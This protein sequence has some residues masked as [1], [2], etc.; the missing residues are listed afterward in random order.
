MLGLWPFNLKCLLQ[1]LVKEGWTRMSSNCILCYPPLAQ[2][3]KAK[4]GVI[5]CSLFWRSKIFREINHCSLNYYFMKWLSWNVFQN[6]FFD[7]VFCSRRHYFTFL[8][9]ITVIN[10][11]SVWV[12]HSSEQTCYFFKISIIFRVERKIAICFIFHRYWISKLLSMFMSCL[13]LQYWFFS[14]QFSGIFIPIY[15]NLGGY[16]INY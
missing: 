12:W 1:V 9:Y 14:I 2:L 4:M 15:F 5:S 3:N 11:N 6:K 13:C 10:L 16:W 8:K 7:F